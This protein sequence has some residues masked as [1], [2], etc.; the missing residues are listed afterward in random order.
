MPYLGLG[1]TLFNSSVGF[2]NPTNLELEIVLTERLLRKKASGAWPQLALENLQSRHNLSDC[3][4]S[5]NR[6]VEDPFEIE[7][8]LNTQFPFFE[9]LKQKNLS[10]F[11]RHTNTN[12]KF[13]S[14][15]FAHA[16]AA[17]LMS[18]FNK[19]LILVI[20]GA[21]SRPLSFDSHHPE[22]VFI[23]NQKESW[24]SQAAEERTVYLLDN[25]RL[26][27]VDKR[28][29]TFQKNQKWPT[30]YM[31]EGLG[32]FYEKISEFIFNSKRSAGK[33]MGL[34]AFA[35]PQTTISAPIN[36]LENINWKNQFAGKSKQEWEESPFLPDYQDAAADAQSY[37]EDNLISYL[38]HIKNQHPEYQNLILTGGCALNC[39]TN[40]KLFNLRFFDEIY[41]PPFPGDECI[42]LGAAAAQY[43][44]D[45]Q[46]W[47]P[48]PHLTQHGFFG[49]VTSV[50]EEKDILNCFS[51]FHIT[52]PHS[53]TDYVSTQ[54]VDGKV[55]GWFQGRSESG[56][57]SLGHRSLLA[58]PDRVGIKDYLNSKIKFRE[59]FRPYG[60]S[61]LHEYADEYFQ[62][63]K[64]FNNPF[65]SFAVK[66]Q[67][68]YASLLAEVTHIDGTSRMQTVR[69]GQCPIF[70]NLIQEFGKKSGIYCVLNTS[71][72]IM[73]EPIVET[74]QDARKF[75][76]T[77]PVDGI[78]V[79]DYYIS[80]MQP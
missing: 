18:P 79:G 39:T 61:T 72:N 56:P 17:T 31:S 70:Y 40:M 20:D 66:V 78:A 48:R 65:M 13:I 76:I 32:S 51:D 46:K 24:L 9:S 75:L 11:S 4:I 15:H 27:C 34:A 47:N 37:F 80:R 19:A 7:K 55:I 25:G 38:K 2:L 49:P 50:P 67:K 54:L 3:I 6:D 8:I 64:D 53:I 69:P 62:V 28:W 1:K 26:R 42:G 59:A 71:L 63:P 43:L 60:C 12:I 23:T 16:S 30:H 77:T 36:Y 29:Q 68:N 52:K 45:T 73:G 33:V 74:I 22:G 14:H 21:G 35:T 41:V 57:R 5:E 58:R 44:S 10:Q